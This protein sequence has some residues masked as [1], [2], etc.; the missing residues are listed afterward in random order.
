MLMRRNA[1]N[2]ATPNDVTSFII[3]ISTIGIAINKHMLINH[4]ENNNWQLVTR[5]AGLF[6]LR[7]DRSRNQRG[8]TSKFKQLI[9]HE[10]VHFCLGYQENYIQK[11]DFLYIKTHSSVVI[12]GH[13]SAWRHDIY[14]QLLPSAI[15]NDAHMSDL[16]SWTF[17]TG[18]D[19]YDLSEW[20]SP[21]ISKSNMS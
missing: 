9:T 20:D 12:F 14:S 5:V 17:L 18:W 8:H 19:F 6:A 15:F 2:V 13:S 7:S 11:Y 21:F 1:L 16:I 10:S 3:L 4:E